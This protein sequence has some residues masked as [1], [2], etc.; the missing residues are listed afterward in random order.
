MRP[1]VCSAQMH[2]NTVVSVLTCAWTARGFPGKSF[3][4]SPNIPRLK[5]KPTHVRELL[6][7]ATNT[8]E[9]V[10]KTGEAKLEAHKLQGDVAT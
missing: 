10:V 9:R 2:A 1:K 3:T 5:H 6:S 4:H 8:G 7:C